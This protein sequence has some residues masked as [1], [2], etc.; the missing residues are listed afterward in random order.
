MKHL[1]SNFFY[2]EKYK[3]IF[4]IILDF[5]RNTVGIFDFYDRLLFII[6]TDIL[7]GIF[8]FIC[9]YTFRRVGL[10]FSYIKRKTSLLQ[11]SE[12]DFDIYNNRSKF[13]FEKKIIYDRSR[14]KYSN[15]N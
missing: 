8:L 3:L 12:A 13:T 9:I 11:R 2:D 5:R 14:C 10:L 15:R 4:V 1:F 7:L 6:L